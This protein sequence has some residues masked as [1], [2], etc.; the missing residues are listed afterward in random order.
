MKVQRQQALLELVRRRPLSSQ[1]EIRRHLARAGHRAT[2]S[3]ISRDL[4]ELGLVRVRGADGTL[5]YVPA[6]EAEAHPAIPAAVLL[7]EFAVGVES[8]RNLV[9]VKTLP[10]AANAV[11]D[12]LDRGEVP[13]ILGTVAGDDTILV[14]V[15]EGASGRRVAKRLRALAGLP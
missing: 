8:S 14:V 15:R 6:N 10:G 1:E 9:L 4:E 3:T 7:Q 5:R 11:A 13:D 12:A 2:Q